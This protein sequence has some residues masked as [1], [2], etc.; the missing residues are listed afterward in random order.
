MHQNDLWG[1]IQEQAQ[2][3]V[4]FVGLESADLQISECCLTKLFVGQCLREMFEALGDT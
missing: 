4:R 2:M 1:D 3:G